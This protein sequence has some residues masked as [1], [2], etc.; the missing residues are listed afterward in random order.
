MKMLTYT[1]LIELR[2][3]IR[4][5]KIDLQSA[6]IKLWGD[7]KKERRSWF[8]KDWKVRRDE[9]IKDKCQICNGRKILTLQH[10]SHPKK[11]I[12]Y[13]S[14]IKQRYTREYVSSGPDFNQDEFVEF[15]NVN[16]DYYPIPLCPQCKSRNPNKRLKKS[17]Q[18]LCTSCKYE[19]DDVTYLPFD[20]LISIFC[21]NAELLQVRDKCFVSKDRYANKHSLAYMKYLFHQ[22][23]LLEIKKEEIEKEAFLLYL[24]DNIHYLSFEDT[25][26]ACKRCAYN[27]DVKE[28]D[29]CPQCK[30]NYKKINYSSCVNCLPDA[31]RNRVLS[32][33]EFIQSHKK[34][35]KDLGID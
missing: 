22:S 27:F 17:P 18:F 12:E 9:I 8:T 25:I 2:E 16:Y 7:N 6:K 34:M 5:E 11:Y 29:L 32:Y 4:N 28:L 24:T 26:T 3:Y 35:E 31:E 14:E 13:F 1:E 10:L 21:V 23:K 33:I 30:I 20:E 19:F 15:I